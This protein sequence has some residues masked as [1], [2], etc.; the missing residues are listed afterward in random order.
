MN[1]QPLNVCMLYQRTVGLVQ[2]ISEDHDIDVQFWKDEFE[3]LID[4]S[5]VT[6]TGGSVVSD[7]YKNITHILYL[8][9]YNR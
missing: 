2:L 9:N 3:S 1:L 7:I 4:R 5:Q 8:L 6:K